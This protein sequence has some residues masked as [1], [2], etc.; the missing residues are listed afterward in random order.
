MIV[1]SLR[2]VFRDDSMRTAY[3]LCL[4]LGIAYGTVLA[5]TSLFLIDVP[6]YDKATVADL[7]AFF[8]LGIAAFAMPMGWAIR[9]LSPA[10]GS[11]S[12]RSCC[13]GRPCAT[14]GS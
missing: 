1:P 13:C 14:A 6:R 3:V 12:R 7:A 2:E 4:L 5:V 11:A 10:R 9:R 8:S